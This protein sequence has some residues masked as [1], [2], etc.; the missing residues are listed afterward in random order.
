M[1]EYS[2][3]FRVRYKNDEK[4]TVSVVLVAN[5]KKIPIEIV[6][7]IVDEYDKDKVEILI[8]GNRIYD[9]VKIKGINVKTIY[10]NKRY[11]KSLMINC[12][13]KNSSGE[14]VLILPS[15][16]D[17]ERKGNQATTQDPTTLKHLTIWQV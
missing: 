10:W 13:V 11:N 5:K 9:K 2:G 6:K 4:P 16:S 1:T 15:Q 8:V 14:Y 7:K 3:F 12:G 17:K